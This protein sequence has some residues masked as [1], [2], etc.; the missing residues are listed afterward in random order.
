[1]VQIIF[2]VAVTPI[3]KVKLQIIP[4]HALSNVLC[5]VHVPA[6]VEK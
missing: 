6:T 3:A 2:V 4:V 1:M 5:S